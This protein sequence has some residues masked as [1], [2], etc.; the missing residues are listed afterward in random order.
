MNRRDFNKLLGAGFFYPLD[1]VTGFFRDIFEKEQQNKRYVLFNCID[2]P[3]RWMFDSILK[4]NDDD[5]FVPYNMIPTNFKNMGKK[6]FDFEYE[7]SFTK[8][9]KYNFPFMWKFEL[10]TPNGLMRPMKDFA[11]NMLIVRGCDMV[12][13]GHEVNNKKLEAP[14]PGGYSISGIF[15]D[16]QKPIFGCITMEGKLEDGTAAN[17]YYSP[18]YGKT[19]IKP[20]VKNYIEH[21]LEPF[22]SE[23]V[24]D[25]NYINFLESIKTNK[26]QLNI[27]NKKREASILI[28]KNYANMVEKY[29]FYLKKYQDLINRSIRHT[30]IKGLT[31]KKIKGLVLPM[32]FDKK[33]HE[34]GLDYKIEDY[35]GTYKEMSHYIVHDDIR[36]MFDEAEII[37]FA[38]QMSLAEIILEFDLASSIIV[39]INSISNYMGLTCHEENLKLIDLGDKIKIDII[40]KEELKTLGLVH[41]ADAHET[42]TLPS[43]IACTLYW[44]AIASSIMELKSSISKNKEKYKNTL[45]HL[46]TEFER[47]PDNIDK[48]SHHGF[49][50]HTSTFFSGSIKELKVI[51]N[52]YSKSL[53]PTDVTPGCGTWGKGAPVKKLDGRNMRYGNIA[54]S[55]ADF[56]GC[57]S[58]MPHRR[59]VFE[60]RNGE[61][62]SLI[63]DAVNKKYDSAIL[64]TEKP[65]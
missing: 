9:G 55:I 23:N 7:Y 58:P 63:E 61:I 20:Y 34:N 32:T 19:I 35:I 2:A 26:E 60:Y 22:R 44:R 59:K 3:T 24:N 4:P 39:N 65:T 40:D 56:L 15:D 41:N 13:D 29:D 57:K 54:S 5:E 28:N 36:N 12:L 62:V 48:G 18:S 64:K 49:T 37:G 42:G 10:P 16:H 53:D 8:V 1:K 45:I 6:P 21:L 27:E 52:I 50:G 25:E 33:K 31:D 30:N 17:A 47:E 14:S 11:E 38:K 43:L 46:T 51:G